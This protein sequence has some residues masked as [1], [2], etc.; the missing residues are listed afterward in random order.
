MMLDLSHPIAAHYAR[1]HMVGIGGIGMS[2]LAQL[3]HSKGMRVSGC[4]LNESPITAHLA[5]SGIP[6]R[7]GHDAAHIDGADF[8]VHTLAANGE[9]PEITAARERGLPVLSRAQLL[10]QVMD[11]YPHSIAVAGTHGKTTTTAL[12]TML[13]NAAGLMPTVL[14]GGLLDAIA[15]NVQISD[16]PYFVAEACEYG[17]SFLYLHPRIGIIL[18][19]DGD[20]LDYYHGMDQV[21]RSFAQFARQIPRNGLLIGWGDDPLIRKLFTEVSCPTLTFGLGAHNQV[22]GQNITF[23]GEG[24]PSFTCRVRGEAY[25]S[26]HLNI[27]GR[28][29]ILNTLAAIALG[30]SLDI[31]P[32]LMQDSLAFF[33]GV[34][35]RFEVMGRS[36]GIVVIDDYAHHPTEI[37]ATLQAVHRVPH[38]RIFC[39]FQPHTYSRTKLLFDDFV[40]AFG[41]I[42]QLVILDIYAAREMDPGTVH[43]RDLANRI[44]RTGLSCVYLPTFTDAVKFLQQNCRAGDLLL[45]MGAGDVYRVGEAF[46]G[47]VVQ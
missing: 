28:H 24:M 25:G 1:V 21:Y 10:G 15:G 18:N 9:N 23:N 40:H 26:F 41:L 17:G 4:D 7:A 42:D 2:A 22:Q 37:Q 31:E 19:I 29:N 20:H 35:R 38:K 12:I 43:S 13:M 30:Y 44:A 45:T 32:T 16:S 34:R 46:L 36:N 8:V 5:E 27:P 39:V 6:V 3:L 11:E 47:K 14:L 33:R